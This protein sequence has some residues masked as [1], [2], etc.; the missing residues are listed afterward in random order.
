[1]GITPSIF[2]RLA[3]AIHEEQQ[4]SY[5]FKGI[6]SPVK[7]IL[8]FKFVLVQAGLNFGGALKQNIN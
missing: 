5:D 8:L 2:P 1:M 6:A 4:C 7:K 3:R